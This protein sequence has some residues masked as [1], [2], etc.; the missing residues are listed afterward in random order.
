[1]TKCG[2]S[3]I[4][5]ISKVKLVHQQKILI[6]FSEKDIHLIFESNMLS[7]QKGRKQ[8]KWNDDNNIYILY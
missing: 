4:I 7:Y 6:L 2:N 3:T 8:G 5:N 1:M